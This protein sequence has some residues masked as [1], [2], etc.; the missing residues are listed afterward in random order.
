M[1][2]IDYIIDTNLNL[3]NYKSTTWTDD[4]TCFTEIMVD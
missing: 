4:I 1:D 2:R 3:F